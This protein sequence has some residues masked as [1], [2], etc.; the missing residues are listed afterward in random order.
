MRITHRRSM[1]NKMNYKL[2]DEMESTDRGVPGG[3]H[4]LSKIFLSEKKKERINK[5]RKKEKDRD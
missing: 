2:N 4:V 1:D 5:K 3:F